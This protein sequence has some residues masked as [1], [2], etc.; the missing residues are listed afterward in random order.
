LNSNAPTTILI[1][2]DGE[3]SIRQ[4]GSTYTMDP[5]LRVVSV[6]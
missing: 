4:N 3:S 5:V 6:Q 2:F 1:D